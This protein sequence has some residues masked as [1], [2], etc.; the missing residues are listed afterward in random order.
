MDA[1]ALS[2]YES[3]DQQRRGKKGG[4]GEMETELIIACKQRI[5]QPFQDSSW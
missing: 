3:L 5:N 4:M 2:T 1:T